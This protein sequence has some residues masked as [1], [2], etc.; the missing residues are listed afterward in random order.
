MSL[1]IMEIIRAAEVWELQAARVWTADGLHVPDWDVS[2]NVAV[3]YVK[4][5]HP[6]YAGDDDGW[7]S[8][9]WDYK[10]DTIP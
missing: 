5:H 3:A 2:F 4:R 8:F 7:D 10:L 1:P 6:V 9:V